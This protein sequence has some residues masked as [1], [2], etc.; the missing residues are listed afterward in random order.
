MKIFKY[1]CQNI[2]DISM[3]C[4]CDVVVENDSLIFINKISSKVVKK[5]GNRYL[6]NIIA[7]KLNNRDKIATFKDILSLWRTDYEMVIA[8][9]LE[10]GYFE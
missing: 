1:N 7:E 6:L 3:T 10:M 8:E 4:F 2:K 9:L 5:R